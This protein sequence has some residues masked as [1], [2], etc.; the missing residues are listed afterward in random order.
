MSDNHS[1]SLIDQYIEYIEVKLIKT[2]TCNIP[3]VVGVPMKNINTDKL[4]KLLN[5]DVLSPW[6]VTTMLCFFKTYFKQ[7]V[8]EN[9]D[10]SVP[11]LIRNANPISLK[12]I[13]TLSERKTTII[14]LVNIVREDINVILKHDLP[15]IKGCNIASLV[16]EYYISLIMN[17]MRYYVPNFMATF[18][19]FSCN[20]LETSCLD[21]LEKRTRYVIYE[22]IKG[23]NFST[24]IINK[25]FEWIVDILG[26]LLIALEVAQR[27]YLFIHNDLHRENIMISNKNAKYFVLL[28]NYK[29]KVETTKGYPIVIDYGTSFAYDG[30]KYIG[31]LYNT[32]NNILD[33]LK[34]VKNPFMKDVNEI[35]NSIFEMVS[36]NLV[37][38][39]KKAKIMELKEFIKDFIDTPNISPLDV[40]MFL[41]NSN[42]YSGMI[43]SIM[44]T[45]RDSL[46][47][48]PSYTDED[49]MLKYLDVYNILSYTHL[50]KRVKEEQKEEVLVKCLFKIEDKIDRNYIL[51][52]YY[53]KLQSI[54]K[55]KP[56][57]PDL[58]KISIKKNVD[59]LLQ[60]TNVNFFKEEKEI[61]ELIKKLYSIQLVYLS[62]DHTIKIKHSTNDINET[63]LAYESFKKEKYDVFTDYMTCYY[64][65]KQL[66]LEKEY[67]EFVSSFEQ[68]KQFK[69]YHEYTDKYIRNA[70][71]WYK[72]IKVLIN[73]KYP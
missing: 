14:K 24:E 15:E 47:Y 16:E 21:A 56:F 46:I 68:S 54:Y 34:R 4:Y 37:D 30:E 66:K 29:I 7:S 41:I 49:Y 26:Q 33:A 57:N 71:K 40:L 65:I 6:D 13:K 17:K 50:Q 72:L 32:D 11:I 28:D 52:L 67:R 64:I 48:I 43:T 62:K 58:D 53:D 22:Y 18:G 38:D 69:L 45:T 20:K 9:Y 61:E 12:N 63:L 42:K 60:Y 70:D 44:I 19:I 25:P 2:D 39:G 10:R 23:E 3:S 5:K 73:N 55:S 27:K 31:S 1:N 51:S 35:F 59:D 36:Q 8:R